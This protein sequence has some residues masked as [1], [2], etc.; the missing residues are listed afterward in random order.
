[1]GVRISLG[2]NGISNIYFYKKIPSIYAT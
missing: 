1:M 2:G